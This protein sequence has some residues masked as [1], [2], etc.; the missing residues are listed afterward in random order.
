MDTEKWF[1]I[2]KE[3]ISANKVDNLGALYESLDLEDII[4]KN[5]SKK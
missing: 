1:Y 4:D 3:D 5:Y 2:D